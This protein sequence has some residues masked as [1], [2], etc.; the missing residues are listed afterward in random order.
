MKFFL[1]RSSSSE[2]PGANPSSVPTSP[3]RRE[4]SKLAAV[5]AAIPRSAKHSSLTLRS[6][7]A[8]PTDPGAASH[9]DDVG[10]ESEIPRKTLK[11]QRSVSEGVLRKQKPDSPG[12]SSSHLSHRSSAAASVAPPVGYDIGGPSSRRSHGN[13]IT[14]TLDADPPGTRQ[15]G[16]NHF[17]AEKQE[18]NIVGRGDAVRSSTRPHLPA[19]QSSSSHRRDAAFLGS[20]QSAATAVGLGARAPRH[21]KFKPRDPADLDT[22]LES[23]AAGE[24]P[25]P[26]R[27]RVAGGGR[28]SE[29][30]KLV[31]TERPFVR[32]P[33]AELEGEEDGDSFGGSGRVLAGALSSELPQ[34]GKSVRRQP[35]PTSAVVQVQS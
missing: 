1:E 9:Q 29:N 10:K 16:R 30:R 32:I 18:D 19:Q 12:Q 8:G 13:P 31:Q 15:A 22:S 6:D 7:T 28:L 2:T 17:V 3:A 25:S 26:S 35:K 20:H 21:H 5:D 27:Q 33:V 23:E 4:T 24:S 11:Q 14:K 34:G